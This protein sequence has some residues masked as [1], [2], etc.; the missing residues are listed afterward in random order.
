MGKLY[1]FLPVF[2]V[3]EKVMHLYT[4]TYSLIA[5][6]LYMFD[7]DLVKLSFYVDC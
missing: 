5:F 4:Y 3:C 2:W 6:V 7:I 1:F